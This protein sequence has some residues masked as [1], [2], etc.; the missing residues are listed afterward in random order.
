MKVITRRAAKALDLLAAGMPIKGVAGAM[1]ID[2]RTVQR[3]I[4]AARI[5]ANC[6]TTYQLLA[7]YSKCRIAV[8]GLK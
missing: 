6:K 5:D 3:V 8:K 7:E 2:R 4:T 1:C